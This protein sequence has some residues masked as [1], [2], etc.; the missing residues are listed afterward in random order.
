LTAPPS[1][2]TAIKSEASSLEIWSRTV[3]AP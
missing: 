1:Q 3:K 2:A